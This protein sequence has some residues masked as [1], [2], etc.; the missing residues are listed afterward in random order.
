MKKI[1]PL[2]LLLIAGNL[3]AQWMGINIMDPAD[4]ATLVKLYQE[5]GGAKWSN[6]AGWL[7]GKG[8][9][10]YGINK[11]YYYC[12]D[13]I[14]TCYEYIDPQT[15][16]GHECTCSGKDYVYNVNKIELPNNNL[17]S[18]L[19]A[20]IGSLKNLEVLD[21]SHN[22]LRGSIP[23]SFGNESIDKIKLSYN[24]LSGDIPTALF[25]SSENAWLDLSHNQLTG[26]IS[27]NIGAMEEIEHLDLSYNLLTGPIPAALVGLKNNYEPL[28]SLDISNN[29]FN[30]DG[31]EE[32]AQ[33]LPFAVY[34]PQD[35]LPA[36]SLKSQM[37]SVY[38]GGNLANNTYRWYLNGSLEKTILGDSTFKPTKTGNYHVTITNSK[39]PALT[40]SS[41]PTYFRLS[42][43]I[44]CKWSGA[45][46]YDWEN[47]G[48]WRCGIVP[49]G[50][51]DVVIEKESDSVIIRSNIISRSITVKPGATLVIAP[52]ASI[53]ITGLGGRTMLD[54]LVKDGNS[55][56]TG[57]TTI[58]PAAQATVK[59][60]R[61]DS[62][63]VNNNPV[64][65]ATTNDSGIVSIPVTYANQYY[66]TAEKNGAL[67]IYNGY[68]VNGVFLTQA[69]VAAA[70]A[71]SPAAVIGGV[72]LTD[73]NGDGIINSADKLPADI[74][75]PENYQTVNKTLVIY[76]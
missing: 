71:Q 24:Q 74:I 18:L 9:L 19:P 66:I 39:A 34:A 76:K 1:L 56:K 37:L 10:W 40:L 52:G 20:S 68:L 50:N 42:S 11:E 8:R 22:K 13:H 63:I 46:S 45:V 61:H 26:P 60:Y 55:W 64:Y 41:K 53:T 28:E 6:K 5:T 69:Q 14:N 62:D 59:L 51:T 48:N 16:I 7:S 2:C 12:E 29:R 47:A 33:G 44:L 15:T 27:S 36:P 72:R 23:S 3:N 58:L 70:P 54:I 4:S 31:M 38:A 25:S 17:D 57:D 35:S 43:F 30:F 49:N 75:Q 73:V 21:L 32:L 67:N 65:I